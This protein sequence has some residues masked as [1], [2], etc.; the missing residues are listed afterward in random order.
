M[1]KK[2][3]I[4]FVVLYSY[5]SMAK[6]LEIVPNCSLDSDGRIRTAL[7]SSFD[8]KGLKKYIDLLLGSGPTDKVT[9]K[10]Q[11]LSSEEISVSERDRLMNRLAKR[12]NIKKSEMKTSGLET[13]YDQPLYRQYYKVSSSKGLNLIAEFYSAFEACAVDLE[14]IYIISDKIDGHTPNFA[15]R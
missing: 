1:F 4:I 7:T 10:I 11:M 3:T 12:D 13:M 5:Y 15:D 14:N 9:Y 2:I 8:E 6:N